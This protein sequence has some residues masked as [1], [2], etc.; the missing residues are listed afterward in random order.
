[1]GVEWLLLDMSEL[2]EPLFRQT[3][4]LA[5]ICLTRLAQ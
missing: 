2:R 3:V 4:T 1:M 5:P